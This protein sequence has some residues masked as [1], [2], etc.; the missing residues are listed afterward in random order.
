MLNTLF[1][2]RTI[3]QFLAKPVEA[4][5]LSQ[6]LAAAVWAPNHGLT[7]PWRFFVLGHQT[8]NALKAIYADQR[9]TKRASCGS[10][11]AECYQ[12]AESKFDAI[13][14]LVLV[15]QVRSENP[16]QLKEDYAACSCAIQ[17]FQLAAWELGLG[18]QW[19]TGPI[20]TDKRTYRLLELDSN[21][22]ELIG[23]LYIGYPAC[24][25]TVNRQ[26]FKTQTRY[27][28]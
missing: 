11:Y 20:L 28:E 13:P 8:K 9:A 26:T 24:V 14:Q 1:D 2:R 23:A 3:Y 7:E 22:L 25:P 17:N 19:S 10:D 21:Q 18:V 6:C 16:V 12:K 4:D 5:K 15:G 27:Y